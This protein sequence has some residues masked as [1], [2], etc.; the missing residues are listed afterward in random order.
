[1]CDY[2][3]SVTTS[4]VP[5]NGINY[6]PSNKNQAVF[7]SLRYRYGCQYIKTIY[8]F[9]CC[10]T[11]SVVLVIARKGLGMRYLVYGLALSGY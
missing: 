11:H 4:E 1:M 8:K 2:N 6:T 7:K 9:S 10:L 3:R 5:E